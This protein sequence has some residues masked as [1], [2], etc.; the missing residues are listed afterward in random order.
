MELQERGIGD[1]TRKFVHQVLN[2]ALNSAV[3][4]GLLSLNPATNAIA[5]RYEHEEMKILD[6]SQVSQFLLAAKGKY[7]NLYTYFAV[8]TGM[9]QAE[10]MGLNGEILIGRKVPYGF[11]VNCRNSLKVKSSSLSQKPKRDDGRYTWARV[12]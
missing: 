7:V 2:V 1:R 6:E 11:S 3:K 12:S 4:E 8:K 5:P 10:L 9:R